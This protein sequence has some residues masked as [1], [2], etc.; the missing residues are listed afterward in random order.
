M[1]GN[2]FDCLSAA[3]S[4]VSSLCVPVCL[5]SWAAANVGHIFWPLVSRP[6]RRQSNSSVSTHAA[7]ECN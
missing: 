3:K 6:R 5:K 4:E 2:R 1:V 7:D